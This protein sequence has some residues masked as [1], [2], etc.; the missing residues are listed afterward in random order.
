MV[1]QAAERE[2]QSDQVRGDV[3]KQLIPLV[4]SFDA[5]QAAVKD[6]SE[7]KIAKAYQVCLCKSDPK[8][9]LYRARSSQTLKLSHLL[10]HPLNHP[11]VEF[12]PDAFW[13]VAQDS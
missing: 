2:R 4:D 13:L 1:I 3:V 10:R 12:N 8:Q 5:A 11:V 6:D 9:L 7:S